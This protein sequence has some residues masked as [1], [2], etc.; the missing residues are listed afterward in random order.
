MDMRIAPLDVKI[1]LESNP[2]CFFVEASERREAG[3]WL[4]IGERIVLDVSSS[5]LC[6]RYWHFT[7]KL[8]LG[9]ISRHQ[10]FHHAVRPFSYLRF[11]KINKESGQILNL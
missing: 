1:L 3:R 6:L 4:L 10:H 9:A 2:L 8:K 7:Q 5:S 11:Q